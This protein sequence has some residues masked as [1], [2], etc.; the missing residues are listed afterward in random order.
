MFKTEW[1]GEELK[2]VYHLNGIYE[3]KFGRILLVAESYC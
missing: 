2:N 1:N 3:T